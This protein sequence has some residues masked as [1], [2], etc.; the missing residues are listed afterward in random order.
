MMKIE[1]GA[2][3]SGWFKGGGRW[4]GPYWPQRFFQKVAFSRIKRE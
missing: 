4:G 1:L 3:C 2:A